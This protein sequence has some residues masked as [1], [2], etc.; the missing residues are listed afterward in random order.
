MIREQGPN[1]RQAGIIFVKVQQI[2]RYSGGNAECSSGTGQSIHYI[3]YARASRT[4]SE[5]KAHINFRRQVR[6][7]FIIARK[8]SEF[9]VVRASQVGV[10]LTTS[11]KGGKAPISNEQGRLQADMVLQTLIRAR[12]RLH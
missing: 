3:L 9:S 10:G 11:T 6:P 12:A 5:H 2:C 4:E 1:D 7:R 8:H